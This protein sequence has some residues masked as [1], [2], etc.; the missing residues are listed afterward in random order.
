MCLGKVQN[1]W[2]EICVPFQRSDEDSRHHKGS[3]AG[4][5]RNHDDTTEESVS[6]HDAAN[7]RHQHQDEMGQTH[8]VAQKEAWLKP[9]ETAATSVMWDSP[10]DL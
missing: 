5:Q 7:P 1:E 9:S 8:S 3:F 10:R 4:A 2:E 6:K